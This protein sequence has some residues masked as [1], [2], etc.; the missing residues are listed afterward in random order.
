MTIRFNRNFSVEKILESFK[1]FKRKANERKRIESPYEKAY[2]KYPQLK[3]IQN[4]EDVLKI[5]AQYD[6]TRWQKRYTIF[7]VILTIAL[8]S[9]QESS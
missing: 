2:K 6:N 9:S 4:R 7:S 8:Q 5:E 3:K 1:E